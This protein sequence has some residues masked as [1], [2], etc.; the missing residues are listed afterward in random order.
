LSE[1]VDFHNHTIPGVD[2]GAADTAASAEALA[3][4]AAQGVRAIVATPHV[5][6]SPRGGLTMRLA[7][8]D[9]GWADLEGVAR[10]RGITVH[11]G[12]ELRLNAADPDLSDSRLRLAGTRFALVEF[13]WFTIP[14]RSARTLAL[15][16][17]RGWLPIVAHPE[18]YDGLDPGLD[19]VR[20]WREAGAYVQVNGP[21][22]LGRY[23]ETARRNALGMLASGCVDYLSSDYHAR[24]RLRIDEY[25]DALVA[26]DGEAHAKLLMVTNPSRLLND[27]RPVEVPSLPGAGTEAE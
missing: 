7:E 8:I 26:M 6:L 23:G 11:R 10:G 20:E 25:W 2:D 12:A 18:R 9:H 24:G 15:I 1:R 21:A 14:P 3:L 19:V 27:E 5:E 17:Q 4:F 13:P 22:L 16:V